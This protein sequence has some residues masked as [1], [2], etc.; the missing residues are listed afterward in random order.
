MRVLITGGAG[1]VGSHAAE[2]FSKK[3]WEVTVLDNLSRQ[4]L[5]G[6]RFNSNVYNWD[7]LSRLKGI[8]MVNGSVL[9]TALL[10]KMVRDADAVIHTAGQVAV[11]TSLSN[12]R[13]DFDTNAG[14]TF[15]VL[16]PAGN[17][18]MICSL[19][20]VLQTRFTERM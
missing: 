6:V 9:Q 16:E 18:A 1:F 10:N 3:G 8:E 7:Y 20:S 14:G 12:P 5:R 13:S 15:N 17:P 11:T 19:S 4:T 2:F